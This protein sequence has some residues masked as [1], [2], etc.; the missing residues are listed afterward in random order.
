MDECK[1]LNYGFREYD[2]EMV[3]QHMRNDASLSKLFRKRRKHS[4]RQCRLNR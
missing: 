1:P 4:V 2:S 3:I